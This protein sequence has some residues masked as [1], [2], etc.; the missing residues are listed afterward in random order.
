[1]KS[2]SRRL[3]HLRKAASYNFLDPLHP[4]LK[5]SRQPGRANLGPIPLRSNF[6][7]QLNEWMADFEKSETLVL[8]IT[9]PM[10]NRSCSQKKERP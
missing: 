10:G 1:M 3:R 9:R 2:L 8:R 5:I 7:P 4:R 6:R